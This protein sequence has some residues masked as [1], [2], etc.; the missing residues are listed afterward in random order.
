MR[1]PKCETKIVERDLKL[2][3]YTCEIEVVFTCS[4]CEHEVILEFSQEDLE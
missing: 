1:C 3:L 2:N 4:K